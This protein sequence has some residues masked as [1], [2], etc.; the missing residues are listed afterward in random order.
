[1]RL[2]DCPGLVFPSMAN[3]KS[4]LVCGG[5]LPIDQLR[6]FNSPIALLMQRIP[7]ELLTAFYKIEI[8]EE[9]TGRMFLQILAKS[10]GASTGSGNPD[11]S[12]MAKRVLKDYT[13]GRLS[14]THL[15]PTYDLALHG[16]VPQSILDLVPSVHDGP[17]LQ[18]LEETKQACGS[19]LRLSDLHP[20]TTHSKQEKNLDEAFFGQIIG[21]RGIQQEDE[22]VKLTKEQ[23]RAIKFAE[24][25]GEVCNF[26]IYRY[27]GYYRD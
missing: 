11:E 5:I 9:Y 14:Y 25:R 27:I 20:H 22:I 3:S 12:S 18:H 19:T 16:Y 2:C 23:K 15:C 17:A 8:P 4:E 24:K 7:R 10:R 21:E 1:M 6:E 26:Y 13:S